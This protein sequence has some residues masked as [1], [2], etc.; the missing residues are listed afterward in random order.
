MYVV[1]CLGTFCNL[2]KLF[3]FIISFFLNWLATAVAPATVVR[4]IGICTLREIEIDWD[5]FQQAL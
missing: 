1:T 4:A 5:S 3:K 2:N